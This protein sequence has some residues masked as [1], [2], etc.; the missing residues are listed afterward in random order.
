MLELL[1]HCTKEAMRIYSHMILFIEPTSIYLATTIL[2]YSRTGGLTPGYLV[3]TIH[4]E[5]SNCLAS[6]LFIHKRLV[7]DIK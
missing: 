4:R 5:R 7:K 3:S 2:A 1:V 6:G